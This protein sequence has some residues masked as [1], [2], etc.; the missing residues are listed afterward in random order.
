[1]AIE[2][3]QIRVEEALP[4]MTGDEF[5]KLYKEPFDEPHGTGADFIAF[6]IDVM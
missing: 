2:P 1:M 6:D 4:G 3:G 5:Y